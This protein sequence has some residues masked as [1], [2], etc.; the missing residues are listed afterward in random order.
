[1]SEDVGGVVNK[2]AKGL[3]TI[4]ILGKILKNNIYVVVLLL[5]L[6]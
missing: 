2:V 4:L 1:M 6:E 3:G 5:P